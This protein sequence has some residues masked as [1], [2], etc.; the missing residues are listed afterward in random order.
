MK[1]LVSE[2]QTTEQITCELSI[3]TYVITQN[4]KSMSIV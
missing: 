2:D 1:I 3:C 4:Q